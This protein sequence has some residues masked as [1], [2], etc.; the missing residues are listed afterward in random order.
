MLLFLLKFSFYSLDRLDWVCEKPSLHF[1]EDKPKSIFF[2][3]KWRSKNVRQFN[4]TC[5]QINT[6]QH[7]QVTYLG[8]VLDERMSC[9]PMAPKVINNINVKLK[10]LYRKNRY[11]TKELD[12]IFCN[13]LIQ[14]DFDYACLTWYSNLKEKTK[15]KIQ[16]MK[17]KK[18]KCVRFCF[19]LDKIYHTSEEQFR[20]INFLCTSKRFDQCTNTIT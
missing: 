18:K 10:L 3:S 1:G 12:I 20:L 15:V 6:K 17:K 2:T 19:K 11:F 8:Y 4:I 14:P 9:E 13:A 5:N 7:S 16:I